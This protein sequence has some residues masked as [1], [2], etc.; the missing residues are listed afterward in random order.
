M[1][2]RERFPIYCLLMASLILFIL[3]SCSDDD[4][5][6]DN[7]TNNTTFTDSRDG[8][9]YKTVTI[10]SQ[11][12][13]AE[14]L[15]FLPSV[16]GPNVGSQISPCYYVFGYDGTDLIQAKA[17][18]NYR[19][20][21]VLYNWEAAKFACPDGWHLPSD[22]EWKSLTTYLGGES[23]AGGKLKEAGTS[24]WNSP[25]VGATNETGF[26]GLPGGNRDI[27]STFLLLGVSGHWWSSSKGSEIDAWYRGI[28]RGQIYVGRNRNG[29]EFG[30]SV[31]CVKD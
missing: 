23:I 2:I 28:Y 24:H 16:I 11:V 25:N 17:A 9:V 14:N 5:D 20:Y 12:W 31:R 26:N 27:S 6:I 22:E 29:K 18:A 1:K 19:T 10:G 4:N 21:G 15:R 8:N 3:G 7:T 13:M 30:F